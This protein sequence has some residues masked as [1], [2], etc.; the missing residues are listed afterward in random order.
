MRLDQFLN[1]HSR[2]TLCDMAKAYLYVGSI[3]MARRIPKL[4][5]EPSEIF[6]IVFTFLKPTKLLL[7]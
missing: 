2:V 5:R 3:L 7:Q 6:M 1:S 4:C